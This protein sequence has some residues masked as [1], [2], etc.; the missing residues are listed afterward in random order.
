MSHDGP[1]RPPAVRKH[2]MV[3]GQVRPQQQYSMSLGTVQKWVLSTLA[4]ITILH[5]AAGLVVAAAY[6][7]KQSSKIGLLVI[8]GVFGVL[9]IEAALVIHKHRPVSWWLLL[10]LVPALAGAYFIF[11]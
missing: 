1:A 5:M 9:A 6:V 4:A 10:G 7:D 2:L 3:P 11:G 8:A